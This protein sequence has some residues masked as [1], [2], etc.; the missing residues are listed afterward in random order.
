VKK[1]IASNWK[2]YIKT[3]AEAQE[4]LDFT[5]DF[6]E[7]RGESTEGSLIFCPSFELI[8]PVANLLK[9]SHLEHES[10]LGIQDLRNDIN[11][12]RIIQSGVGYVIIGHSDRRWKDGESNE[13]TNGKLKESLKKELIPIVC[14]GEKS[15]DDNFKIFIENQIDGT[16][17][18]L[19]AD[20]IE[21][22]IITYEPVWAIS[23]TPG[24]EPDN[25]DN[26]VQKINFIKEALIS[27]FE[28]TP[29]NYFLYGGSVNSDNILDFL[30][31]EEING[32]L[33]GRAS[34]DKEEFV[35]ILSETYKI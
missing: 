5:N 24:S 19:D 10:F 9:K 3:P 33:I 25:P 17:S 18:G 15:R 14:L 28:I 32:V 22:C 20:Q 13:I 6:L 1:I 11:I 26:A 12:E 16:F 35:K 8:D 21:K 4:I 29:K 7:S 31:K 2:E 30:S 34:T 27:K 23:V